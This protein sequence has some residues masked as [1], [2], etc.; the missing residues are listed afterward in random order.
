MIK[1]SSTEQLSPKKKECDA[2]GY[3][4]NL[5]SHFNCPYF[6]TSMSNLWHCARPPGRCV[7]DGRKPLALSLRNFLCCRAESGVTT[8]TAE[9]SYDVLQRQVLPGTAKRGRASQKDVTDR[10]GLAVWCWWAFGVKSSLSTAA[11]NYLLL[12]WWTF[13]NL[14][15]NLLHHWSGFLQ[16]KLTIFSK[17]QLCLVISIKGHMLLIIAKTQWIYIPLLSPDSFIFPPITICQ[18]ESRQAWH[19]GP[20]SQTIYI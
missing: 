1:L 20:V 2:E 4:L 14:L 7:T 16:T 6:N 10:D 18:T 12:F 13:K 9:V 19:Q 8:V 15:K 11:M 3:L 5:I 17:L